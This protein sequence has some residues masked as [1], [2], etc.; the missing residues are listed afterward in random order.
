MTKKKEP[1]ENTEEIEP[2]EDE[3]P[4]KKSEDENEEFLKEARARL[5]RCIDWDDH[6]VQQGIH[7][8]KFV[9]VKGEQWSEEDKT[10]RKGRPTLESN[11]LIQ[12]VE[13][14][15]GEERQSRPWIKV[16]PKSNDA[17]M[18]AASTRQGYINDI[19]YRSNAES[20]FDYAQ[21]MMAAGNRGAWRVRTRYTEEDPFVQEVY[22]ERLPNPYVVKIGPCKSE[23]YADCPYMFIIEKV[24]EEEYKERYGEKFFESYASISAIGKGMNLENWYDKGKTVTIAEYFYREKESK[25]FWLMDDGTILEK[26]VAE[27]KIKNFKKA[28]KQDPG[29]Q[30]PEMKKER[31]IDTFK[32]KH[33]IINGIEI[34][35]KI[36]TVPGDFIPVVIANG[37]D[38]NIDGKTYIRSAVEK[39]E[40]PQKMGNYWRSH[41]AEIIKIQPKAPYIGTA[42]QVAGYEK[43]YLEANE[44]NLSYLPYNVDPDTPQTKPTREIPGAPPNALFQQLAVCDEDIRAAIGMHRAGVGQ[45]DKVYSG[46]AL[47][48]MA[49]PGDIVAFGYI[50]NLRRNVLYTGKIINSMMADVIDTA[51]DL[52]QRQSDETAS[53]E[54]VNTT[55][56]EAISKFKEDPQRYNIDAD[57]K[58][59][60]VKMMNDPKY[61]PSHPYNDLKKGT[62]EVYMTVGPQYSTQ[63]QESA[64]RLL[65]LARHWPKL[66]DIGGDILLGMQDL[67]GCEELAARV[68]RVIPPNIAPPKE[69]EA[70]RQSPP[71]TP[72]VMLERQKFMTEKI[73]TLHEQIKME[74]DLKE[75]QQDVAKQI[76]MVVLQMLQDIFAEEHPAD[77]T[78]MPQQGATPSQPQ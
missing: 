53:F 66:L 34:L 32:I 65:E 13:Q 51:R 25:D 24:E 63:R 39:A 57:K 73:K 54:P 58:R 3:K 12:Y 42:K 43:L 4:E 59:K 70:P 35:E 26:N 11:Q 74:K 17:T 68:K 19:L 33:C 6:N 37:K 45:I 41:L 49:K 71:P 76:K 30:I 77:Q 46:A 60:L 7:N 28:A 40:D 8:L 9:Y 67:L 29:V 20:I 15:V 5:K 10:H 14:I 23:V 38:V 78:L 36:K 27:E 18:Q 1:I 50:D 31:T 61:G 44:T 16:I 21:E 52:R 47:G 22:L 48:A 2:E 55:L 56:G 69:G 62:Y 72:K 64:A 75:G